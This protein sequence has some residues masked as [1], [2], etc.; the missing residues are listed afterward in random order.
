MEQRLI[1]V[2]EFQSNQ[3]AQI[4]AIQAALAAHMSQPPPQNLPTAPTYPL[5]SEVVI[6]TLEGLLEDSIRRKVL[7]SLQE[8][9]TTVEGAVKQRNEEL[10][11]MFGKKFELLRVGIG[12]LEKKILQS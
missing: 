4:Q 10:Q 3:H 7:P 9:Q 6:E 12:Q 2:E 8:M 11:Q 1:K 5:N